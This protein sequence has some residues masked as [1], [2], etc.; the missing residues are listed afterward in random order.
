MRIV[1][2]DQ[3][4]LEAKTP[5]LGAFL[6]PR[7]LWLRVGV[8]PKG[9]SPWSFLVLAWAKSDFGLALKLK[10]RLALAY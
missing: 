5:S 4:I 8:A 10:A 7:G 9:F 6:V 3:R 1:S 2:L